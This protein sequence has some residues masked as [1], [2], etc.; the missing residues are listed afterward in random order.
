MEH[1]RVV[2]VALLHRFPDGPRVL[3]ARRT[4]PP[5]A[6]GG[7]EFPG[8]KCDPGE[9]LETAAVREVREELACEV[10]VTGRLQGAVPVKPGY[11]LEVVV[12][13][14][15][16]GEPAPL[17]H[18]ALRWLRAD[19]LGSVRWLPSDVPFLAELRTRLEST[20]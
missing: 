7:W 10:R 8:G 11:A 5:D 1:V 16:S 3:A 19:E 9:S 15:V 18:D 14:L 17:E 20:T 12:G 4:T 6:A 13:E 2:G